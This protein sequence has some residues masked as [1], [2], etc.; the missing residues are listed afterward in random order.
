MVAFSE[1]SCTFICLKYMP[2]Y[3]IGIGLG[4]LI[5]P[6]NTP[7][8]MKWRPPG[9]ELY[10]EGGCWHVV[11][12]DIPGTFK[13]CLF[14]YLSTQRLTCSSFLGSTLESLRRKI[15]HNPKGP[16]LEPLSIL[17]IGTRSPWIFSLFLCASCG[18]I[19]V[20]LALGSLTRG[21]LV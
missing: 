6:L 21:F 17:Q 7:S 4:L 13:G 20:S 14:E 2:Q 9:P 10:F 16:T 19:F 12:Y 15:G 1:Y 18:H 8:S 5:F 11:I 3:Y